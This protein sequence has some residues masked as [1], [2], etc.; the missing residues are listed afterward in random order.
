M[1]TAITARRALA[2]V[3]RSRRRLPDRI[4]GKPVRGLTARPGRGLRVA[5]PA[6]PAP[7]R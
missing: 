1:V 4:A 3:A 2:A 6:G 5:W 7:P